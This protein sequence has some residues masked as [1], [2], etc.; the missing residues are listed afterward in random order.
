MA[1]GFSPGL[2]AFAQNTQG[3]A[4]SLNIPSLVSSSV[5]GSSEITFTNHL[6]LHQYMVSA[7]SVLAP[8]LSLLLCL[9]QGLRTLAYDERTKGMEDLNR[10]PPQAGSRTAPP[11]SFRSPRPVLPSASHS[12]SGWCCYRAPTSGIPFPT[13]SPSPAFPPPLQ[14]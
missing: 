13:N 1:L 4:G 7:H 9:F 6:E 3:R 10:R 2:P 11:A 8:S 14:S 5:E 12:H